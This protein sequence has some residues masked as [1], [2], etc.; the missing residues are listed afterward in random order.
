MKRIIPGVKQDENMQCYMAW[1]DG[2]KLEIPPPVEM[3]VV[4]SSF[5]TGALDPKRLERRTP[6]GDWVPVR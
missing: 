1:S 5:V 3:R 2:T 4:G 6:E